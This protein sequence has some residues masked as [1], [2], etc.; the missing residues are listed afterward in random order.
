MSLMI[1]HKDFSI[2]IVQNVAKVFYK[3]LYSNLHN[4]RNLMISKIS[5]HIITGDPKK[6]L[7]RTWC[8]DLLN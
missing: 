6:H 7:K 5:I 8:L 2:P 1:L 3:R 4:H